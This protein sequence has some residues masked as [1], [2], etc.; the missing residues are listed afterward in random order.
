FC[1][2]LHPSVL[3]HLIH[4]SDNRRIDGYV[5]TTVRHASGASLHNQNLFSKARVHGINGNKIAFLV[6]S[7][8]VDLTANEQLFS[9]ESRVLPRCD[10]GP[11]DT[12]EHH[13]CLYL[14]VLPMG[15][16]S[17]RFECGLGITWTLMSSPTRRAA[18][19]PASVAAFTA[20]TSPR[21][22]AVT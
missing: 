9:L 12:G 20:A 19:A 16:T 14:D 15:R 4:N 5:L 11:D 7:V 17:S 21:T 6:I 1:G 10:N 8:R 13:G 3:C 22:I 2:S 18:A